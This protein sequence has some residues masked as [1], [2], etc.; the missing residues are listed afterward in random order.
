MLDERQC[1]RMDLIR[2]G[3]EGADDPLRL[4]HALSAA[5]REL[6]FAQV[7]VMQMSPATDAQGRIS[8]ITDWGTAWR[9]DYLACV[10][11][12][13]EP[14]LA[15]LGTDPGVM[16]WDHVARSS[17]N[18]P[19]FAKLSE[20]RIGA[21]VSCQAYAANGARIVLMFSGGDHERVQNERKKIFLWATWYCNAILRNLPSILPT[22]KLEAGARL[23]RR[24][25]QVVLLAARGDSTARIAGKLSI[26]ESTVL[27]FVRSAAQKMAT[28]GRNRSVAI[29]LSAGEIQAFHQAEGF[30][31]EAPL[32]EVISERG[33][34]LQAP[35][36][37]APTAPRMRDPMPALASVVH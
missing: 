2:R 1:E 37:P 27:Y 5:A 30:R 21:A 31:V 4:L 22:P 7:A 34:V 36:D 6:G 29:A 23:T 33:D 15:A 14:V 26:A 17:S 25:S 13:R 35:A 10:T 9:D 18:Q 8:L 24:E 3:I 28:A 32:V 12:H 11:A 16:L 19:F 20:A